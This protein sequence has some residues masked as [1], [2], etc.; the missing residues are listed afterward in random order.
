MNN[1]ITL[2]YVFDGVAVLFTALQSE[3]IFQIISLILTAISICVS[4][5]FTI[6]KWIKT[7]KEDGKIT[8]EEIEDLEKEINEK[9]NSK[10]GE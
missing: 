10:K 3:Q 8:K 2:A 9:I 7:A 1:K 6:W 5:G 4:L